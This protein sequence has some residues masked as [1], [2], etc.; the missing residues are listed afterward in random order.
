MWKLIFNAQAEPV[1]PVGASKHTMYVDSCDGKLTIKNSEWIISKVSCWSSFDNLAFGNW[2][3]WCCHI[4]LADADCQWHVFMCSWKYNLTNFIVDAWVTLYFCWCDTV[5][6]KINNCF[7]NMWVIN[8][9]WT[10][11]CPN[12]SN[13]F[14]IWWV[15]NVQNMWTLWTFVESWCSHCYCNW[16]NWQWCS[17]STVWSWTAW[18]N[19]YRCNWWS[20]W[21]AHTPGSWWCSYYWNWWDGWSSWSSNYPQYNN[22]SWWHS[23]AGNWWNGWS[24]WCNCPNYY[25]YWWNSVWWAYW[26]YI[27]APKIYNNC[28]YAKWWNGWTSWNVDRCWC[29]TNWWTVLIAYRDCLCNCWVNVQWWTWKNMPIAGTLTI[30]EIPSCF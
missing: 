23:Y 27:W 1:A 15:S 6:L 30:V 19:S 7:C 16:G 22:A 5:E 12:S 24:W 9:R 18:W 13:I 17:Y 14:L 8:T 25:W 3:D 29:W 4:T 2:S 10:I 11:V 21:N 26:L 28:I 20:W